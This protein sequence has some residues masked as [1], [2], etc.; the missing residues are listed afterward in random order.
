LSIQICIAPIVRRYQL[1]SALSYLVKAD[2]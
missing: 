2:S 1:T